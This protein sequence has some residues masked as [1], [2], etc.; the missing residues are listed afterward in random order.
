[1]AYKKLHFIITLFSCSSAMYCKEKDLGYKCCANYYWNL[2]EGNCTE[3]MPG[4]FGLNCS[5]ECTAGYYGLWCLSKCPEYCKSCN[6][7]NGACDEVKTITSEDLTMISSNIKMVTSP[8][9]SQQ[10]IRNTKTFSIIG[11][12]TSPAPFRQSQRGSLLYVIISIGSFVVLVLLVVLMRNIYTITTLQP[13]QTILLQIQDQESE[14]AQN[15]VNPAF[16]PIYEN[17]S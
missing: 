4:T 7:V 5:D 6:K 16:D 9:V 13:K 17:P 14:A 2:T 11:M 1:M 12:L 15:T 3:C 8:T 10:S